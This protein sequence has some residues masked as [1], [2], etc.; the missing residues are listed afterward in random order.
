MSRKARVDRSSEEKWQIIEEGLKSGNVS[1]TCLRH[2]IATSLAYFCNCG[3]VQSRGRFYGL[4]A[5]LV[6]I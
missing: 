2:S 3:S 4:D 6:S 5:R 1:E